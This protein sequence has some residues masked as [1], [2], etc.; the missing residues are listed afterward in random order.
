MAIVYK[1]IRNNNEIFYIGIGVSEKR[2]YSKHSRNK[3]WNNITNK[4]DYRVAIICD[5]V[6]YE[7]AKHIEK[8][9]IKFYGRRD[10]GLGTLVNFT[11]GGEGF[12]N[13]NL[14]ERKR[15]SVVFTKYNK[16][17]KDYSFT[18]LSEYKT[19]MSKATTNKGCKKVK[20]KLTGQIYNSQK[21]ASKSV[22]LS[23]SYLSEM[24]N[25]KKINKTDLIWS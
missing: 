8:Y 14:K 7:T 4:E 3:H 9:L 5:D 23:V 15:R 2:A 16:T 19:K 20:N 1:H 25:N 13:M 10:L 6:D 11:D 24:L 12:L 22:G 21:D 17:Q 18:Q